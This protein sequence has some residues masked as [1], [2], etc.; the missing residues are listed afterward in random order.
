MAS[1]FPSRGFWPREGNPNAIGNTNTIITDLVR[2]HNG[3]VRGAMN[4][5]NSTDGVN[6]SK[7]DVL[8]IE[9][10]N[11]SAANVLALVNDSYGNGF[12]FRSLDTSFPGGSRL[13][14]LT[15][16]WNDTGA[17]GANLGGS[18]SRFITLDGNG[19]ALFAIPNNRNNSGIET[20]RGFVVYGYP[21]P[22]GTLS[23]TG[24]TGTIPADGGG[25]P[26]WRRRTTP[27]D[28]VT[29]ATF[30]LQL[31]TTRTDAADPAG[32]ANAD[33][34]AV[35]RINR[36]FRDYNGINPNNTAQGFDQPLG[37]VDAGYERFVTQ[38]APLATTPGATNGLYRQVIDAS[39]L[40]EGFNYISTICYRRRT[41]GGLPVFTDFR[42]VIYVDRLPPQVALTLPPNNTIDTAG[43]Q[44]SV[45]ASDKCTNLVYIIANVPQGV[46]PR[47]QP[48]TYLTA[49]NQA[50]R[51]DRFD[52]RRNIAN[53]PAGTNNITVVAFELS[54]NS[55]VIRY[56]NIVNVLGSGDVNRDG[57]VN[58]DDL[59][60]SWALGTTYQA[61]ADMNRDGFLD[62]IDRRILESGI[63]AA[64]AAGMRNTQR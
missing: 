31:T 40:P 51:I 32:N 2:I 12:Q 37:G 61:E 9:R 39:L 47:T 54:G 5:I 35:F 8:A 29:G 44:F 1:R 57:V 55:T 46:D 33:D 6:P 22:S 20:N 26:E 45:L 52:F 60:A 30:E 14:E 59:H 23:V 50:T 63:R 11:G 41:D 28:V 19:R 4:I 7:A 10:A 24:V 49:A 3:F 17:S 18:V 64:E 38:S 21:P 25:V 53:L 48:A 13:M 15:G 58:L 36:G 27:V 62:A 42:K 34:F 16:V 56:D 43:F